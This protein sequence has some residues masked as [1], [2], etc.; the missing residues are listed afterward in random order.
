MSELL[1]QLKEELEMLVD[2]QPETVERSREGLKTIIAHIEHLES[3]AY[4]SEIIKKEDQARMGALVNLTD[5]RIF[6]ERQLPPKE[7]VL[8]ERAPLTQEE[9]ELF[10]SIKDEEEDDEVGYD[11]PKC[12]ASTGSGGDPEEEGDLVI[13]CDS[14]GYEDQAV[15]FKHVKYS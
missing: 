5:M 12:D 11:C 15:N 9:E 13:T 1:D 8:E 6:L 4:K 3:D 14:C 7:F 2:N 10:Q